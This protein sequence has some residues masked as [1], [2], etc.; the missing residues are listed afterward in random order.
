V[1]Y[2]EVSAPF[3]VPKEVPPVLE[4]SALL[5]HWYDKVPPSVTDAITLKM[6]LTPGEMLATFK[7]CLLIIGVCASSLLITITVAAELV[8]VTTF[9]LVAS[10]LVFVITQ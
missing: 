8:T 6:A 5:Y 3:S 1:V 4:S 9:V 2:V 7:G 10:L